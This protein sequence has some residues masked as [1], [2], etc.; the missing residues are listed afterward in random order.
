[1]GLK[2][3]G[4]GVFLIQYNFDMDE[5]RLR[6]DR[7][8]RE[9]DGGPLGVTRV[10]EVVIAPERLAE[11]RAQWTKLLGSSEAGRAD[12]WVAGDGPRIRLVKTLDSRT[13]DI[14]VEVKSL[15]RAAE[16]LRRL[17]ISARTIK[18]Q[19]R[20]DPDAMSGLRLVLQGFSQK[21]T[22]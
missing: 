14:V 18:R 4:H 10:L 9:R 7:V 6:F 16:A 15:T 13:G 20:I 19:I 2:G 1:V 8:L 11:A 5:R 22:R 12:V 21:I 3:F 17:Q